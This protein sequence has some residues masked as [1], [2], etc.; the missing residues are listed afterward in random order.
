MK[1]TALFLSALLGPAILTVHNLKAGSAVVLGPDNHLVSSYGHP[2]AVAKQRALDEA[3][4]MFGPNVRILAATDITGYGAV[5]VARHPNGYGWIM[6]AALGKRSA[7]EAES[8]AIEQC[9]KA[10]GTNPKVRWRFR[11]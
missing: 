1:K 10:G 4:Q 8:L 3:R 2:E 5:A 11:G 9:V 6:A 7:S